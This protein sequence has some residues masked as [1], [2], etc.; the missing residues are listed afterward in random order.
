MMQK[1]IEYVYQ[2]DSEFPNKIK[3]ALPSE[4]MVL[5]EL[6][7]VPLPQ[8]YKNFLLYMGRSEGGLRITLDGTTCIQN[9]IEFYEEL[10]NPGDLKTPKG[11]IVI[12]LS[13]YESEEQY[14]L[15]WEISQE[16]IYLTHE[17]SIQLL[18]ASSLESLLYRR[19][20]SQF[21][22]KT[23][24]ESEF[25]TNENTNWQL[26]QASQLAVKEGF[27]KLWFSD[28]VAFCGEKQ[29]VSIVI[30]QYE[31]RGLN[32]AIKANSKGS[33]A[34]VSRLFR[35]KFQMFNC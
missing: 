3:A 20:F 4:I 26:D 11:C 34:Q 18:Y 5:E 25:L 24:S 15:D 23:L 33:I 30:S 32:M 28:D 31:D 21:K 13:A 35:N 7:G 8:I 16:K 14:V 9:I 12:G 2:F 29:D 1:F 10:I 27:N 22:L 6:V 17:D 19:A